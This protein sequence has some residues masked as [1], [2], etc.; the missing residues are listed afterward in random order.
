MSRSRFPVNAVAA[1]AASLALVACGTDVDGP[2]EARPVTS[3]ASLMD[4]L[5]SAGAA[6]A[7]G[8]PVSQVFL[9]A[10]GRFLRVNGQD[11]QVF[12]YASVGAAEADAGRVSPD[13]ETIGTT[14]VSWIAPPHFYRSGPVIA[15]YVGS[16]TS[17][18][19]AL[20]AV[21]GRQFAG[22]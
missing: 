10:D 4:A 11:V 3:Y 16:D 14:H 18:L 5:R 12:E 15:L 20:E 2:D 9:S 17:V 7:S 22:S 19:R 13:G 8:D 6:V 1:L 21:L